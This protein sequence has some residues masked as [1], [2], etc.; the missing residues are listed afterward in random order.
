METL[1]LN[2]RL[3]VSSAA[4]DGGGRSPAGGGAVGPRAARS[5]R[6]R[7]EADGAIGSTDDAPALSLA[8]PQAAARESHAWSIQ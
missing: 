6:L 4:A 3:R 1:A 7:G 5:A 8:E 2:R